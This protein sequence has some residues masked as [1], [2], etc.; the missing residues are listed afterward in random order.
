MADIEFLFDN[1]LIAAVESLIK[2]SKQELLLVSPFIDLDKR[3]QDAL[4]EKIEL[5]NFKLQVLFGKNEN[6]YYKSVKKD[7]FDFLRQF[8]NIEIRYNERLHAKYYKND[9]NMIFTSMNL[10]DYSLAK[11]IEVGVLFNVA[12]KGL[13]GKV[14]TGTENLINNGID[15]VRNEVLGIKLEV[16]PIQKFE[17][18]F[19]DST[20]LYKTE[21][22]MSDKGGLLGVFG[23]KKM[24]G[25]NVLKDEL[26]TTLSK[27]SI[28]ETVQSKDEVKV[29]YIPTSSINTQSEKKVKTLSASQLSKNIGVTPAEITKLMQ[30]MKL[31]QGDEITELGKD[32]GLVMKNYMGN[33]YIAYP[34]DLEEFKSLRS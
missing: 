8:P 15:K 18:I 5:P 33:S 19:N 21:P 12:Y 28:T 25:I 13:I 4:K 3:I 1:Q 7:S 32:K 2:E 30:D 16:D 26:L 34:E 29:N 14:L 9:Y 23:S 20:L 17:T 31:I 24:S 22:V 11:N 10:Y 27:V 6:N